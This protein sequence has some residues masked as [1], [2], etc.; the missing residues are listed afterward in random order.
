MRIALNALNLTETKAGVGNYAWHII[1][2]LQQNPGEHHFTVYINESVKHLFSGSDGMT[3][4]VLGNFPDSKRRLLYELTKLADVLNGQNYDLIHFLDYVV[5]PQALKAPF[6][7]TV[8]D[9]SFFVSGAYFT[10][11]MNVV[12]RHLLPRSC[13]RA[14]GILTV[15][16]FTKRELLNY[17][18]VPQEKVFPVLLGAEAP[19]DGAEGGE[20]CVLCVGTIEP[21]KNQITAMKAMELLWRKNPDFSLP[22]VI[23]GKRGWRFE[24]VIR[25]AENSPFRDRIRFV[26]YCS[27]AQLNGWYRNAKAFVFPSLYEGFGLPPLEA[28]R[29]GV[30]VVS[31]C[32]GSLPEVLG[33]AAILC[34][35]E[36]SSA[37]AE[38]IESVLGNTAFSEPGKK[39]AAELSWK[40]TA[41]KT[42]EIY[43]NIAERRK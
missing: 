25:Y 6:C 10:K 36:D 40:R 18:A 5:P 2:E 3:F 20:P 30:P 37:F 27:E 38:G 12:K 11:S 8:H 42:M 4:S 39:R 21:R 13:K 23:V 35:P 43:R 32:A 41:E 15:S 26:G 22:L 24:E 19:S 33:D 17:V 1:R 34:P 28:M 31:S 16:E 14:A 9:V 7:V 29:F